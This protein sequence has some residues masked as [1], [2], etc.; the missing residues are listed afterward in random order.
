MIFPMIRIIVASLVVVS[1]VQ[2]STKLAIADEK[3]SAEPTK[4]ELAA[5]LKA[6][7]EVLAMTDSVQQAAQSAKVFAAAHG[8]LKAQDEKRAMQLFHRGLQLSPWRLDEQMAYAELLVRRNRR[9]EAMEIAGMVEG[10]TESDVLFNAA[11]KMQRKEALT[12]LPAPNAKGTEGP[13]ICLVLVGTVNQCVLQANVQKLQDAL[14]IPVNVLGQPVAAG[15]SD[16]SAFDR[17]VRKHLIKRLNWQTPGMKQYLAS[18]KVDAPEKLTADQ[19]HETVT[20]VLRRESMKEE[21]EQ[22]TQEAAFCRAHEE[23]WD[24]EKLF[25]PLGQAAKDTADIGNAV[26]VGITELD[27]YAGDSNYL[28]GTAAIGAG[29]SIVSYARYRG[30]FFEEPQDRKR[31]TLRMH[32]QLLSSIGNALGVPRPTDP[33]SARSYP[34]SLQEHDAKSEYMSEACIA[35]FERALKVT[36]PTSAH[37]PK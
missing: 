34:R 14:G 10:Q 12:S 35:G 25:I 9:A 20:S 1:F 4:E 32:K 29:I 37:K 28:F 22:V 11:R 5:L 8:V 36:L 7:D 26:I 2:V 16:R 21:L 6:S 15:K 33:T 27:I 13:W 24:A 30:D 19:I 3:P 23:Q 18:Q 31:L 17:W